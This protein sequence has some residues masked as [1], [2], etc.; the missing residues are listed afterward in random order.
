PASGGPEVRTQ[1]LLTMQGEIM[2]RVRR[3]MDALAQETKRRQG[4]EEQADQIDRH[5]SELEGELTKHQQAAARLQQD[6]GSSKK[7]LQEQQQSSSAEQSKLEARI[8]DLQAAHEAA[9]QKVSSLTETLAQQ[10]KDRESA[11]SQARDI[12]KRRSDL[13]ARLEQLRKD[14]KDSE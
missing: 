12:E 11:E 6:P 8:K 9:E 7:Q 10:T 13:E 2:Q 14:L 4:A 3:L 5:R 1:E